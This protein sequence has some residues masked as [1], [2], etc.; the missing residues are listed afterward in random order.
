MYSIDINE[1]KPVEITIENEKNFLLDLF[2]FINSEVNSSYKVKV[3][4]PN[5]Y[6]YGKSFY[7]YDEKNK[8][9]PFSYLNACLQLFI[10]NR[11][12]NKK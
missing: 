4:R 9:I 5:E 10:A 8:K 7:I 6:N 3:E 11:K 12:S 1:N 2:K